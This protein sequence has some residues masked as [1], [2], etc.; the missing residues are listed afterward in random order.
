MGKA[1]TGV[2]VW[3]EGGGRTEI[4]NR[5]NKQKNCS[6]LPQ[7]IGAVGTFNFVPTTLTLLVEHSTL[8]ANKAK[9]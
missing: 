7:S 8:L 2:W 9:I 4:F 3:V 1:D 5:E 6:Y